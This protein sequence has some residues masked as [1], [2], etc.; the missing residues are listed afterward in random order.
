MNTEIKQEMIDRYIEEIG[1]Q[2]PRQ[3][4]QDILNEIQSLILDT[5][6]DRATETN[7]PVNDE[8]ITQI[9]KEFGS[10]EKMALQYG[11]AN[12]LIGPRY[13]SLYQK[14]IRIVI[15]VVVAVS[16][17]GFG[18]ALAQTDLS[19]V[20][21]GSTLFEM[22]GTVISAAFQAFGIVTLIF[23]SLERTTPD[24][25]KTWEEKWSPDK[26]M[27][28]KPE[29][30]IKISEYIIEITVTI[31]GLI[32]IN[33]FQRYIGLISYSAIDNQWV[34][35]PVLNEFFSRYVPY[36]NV[37]W[38]GSIILDLYILNRGKLDKIARWGKVALDATSLFILFAIA[39]GPAILNLDNANLLNTVYEGLPSAMPSINSVLRILLT[40]AMVGTF[41]KIVISVYKLVVEKTSLPLE[42]IIESIES[43]DS[44]KS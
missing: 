16:L 29:S 10:P 18:I 2:L 32:M 23:F 19:A 20:S 11:K 31:I 42:D 24:H 27:E 44:K 15:T 21:L 22:L 1:Q 26:L 40:L 35:Y 25:W 4:K 39:V 12:Y 30:R 17:A 8:L 6:E 38:I 13:F 7:T 33:F 3:G 36:L 41:V 37:F 43:I 9:L 28:K 34:F 14:I 5:L